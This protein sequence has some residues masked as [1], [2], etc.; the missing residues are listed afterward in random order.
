VQQTTAGNPAQALK[1][2]LLNKRSKIGFYQL[3]A[4]DWVDVVSALK[5]DAA[6]TA[7]LAASISDWPGNSRH[8]SRRSKIGW[9][10]S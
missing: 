1:P 7:S 2:P 6:K 5:A 3:S 10:G 8:N 4:L 9:Q